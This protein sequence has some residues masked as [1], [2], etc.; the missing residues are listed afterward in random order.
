MC[1]FGLTIDRLHLSLV[2]LCHVI[3]LNM[4]QTQS[5]VSTAQLLSNED[6]CA[7][8]KEGQQPQI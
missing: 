5:I 6:I 8:L 2:Q 4:G 3:H 1:E 7:F